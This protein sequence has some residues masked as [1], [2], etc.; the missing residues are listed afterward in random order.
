L[1]FTEKRKKKWDEWEKELARENDN[2]DTKKRAQEIY[3][4]KAARQK[5]HEEQYKREIPVDTMAEYVR[6]EVKAAS[7]PREYYFT[8][9]FDDSIRL[10]DGYDDEAE[11][12]KEDK[13]LPLNGLT[14][15]TYVK[16]KFFNNVTQAFNDA[17]EGPS[18]AKPDE[19]VFA[20]GK[21]PE[22]LEAKRKVI[23]KQKEK[24]FSQHECASRLE[25]YAFKGPFFP[26]YKRL[27]IR[28]M[29]SDWL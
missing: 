29:F 3:A 9:S 15:R 27:F 28:R 24:K 16:R 5:A 22:D 17:F 6:V 10:P 20:D 2:D 19:P 4:E 14:L 18:Y 26:I 1:I 23:K 7:I 21:A 8:V 11:F 13:N 25:D 12:A